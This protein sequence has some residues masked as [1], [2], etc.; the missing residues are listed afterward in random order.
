MNRTSLALLLIIISLGIIPIALSQNQSISIESDIKTGRAIVIISEDYSIDKLKSEMKKVLEKVSKEEQD[1]LVKETFNNIAKNNNLLSTI[2]KRFKNIIDK[3]F[4]GYTI[5]IMRIKSY[6]EK[7]KRIVKIVVISI[8]LISKDERK[9]EE[10]SKLKKHEEGHAKINEEIAKRLGP[11]LAKQ[12][13]RKDMNN[14]EV[15]RAGNRLRS[16]LINTQN[17]AHSKYDKLTDHGRK[18]TAS[19]QLEKADEAISEV[20][21]ESNIKLKYLSPKT[22]EVPP[23]TLNDISSILNEYWRTELRD[24]NF[25]QLIDIDKNILELSRNLMNGVDFSLEFGKNAEYAS[26][27]LTLLAIEILR[28][29]DTILNR[30]RAERAVYY[31]VNLLYYAQSRNINI[32]Q[33]RR[34]Y[35]EIQSS[36]LTDNYYNAVL[37]A[38]DISEIIL[39]KL[40]PKYQETKPYTL[41]LVGIFSEKEPIKNAE[42]LIFNKETKEL[43]KTSSDYRGVSII[44][45]SP[46][47]C[48]YLVPIKM[49]IVGIPLISITKNFLSWSSG[50]VKAPENGILIISI[51]IK[52]FI[53]FSIAMPIIENIPNIAI[54]LI[55]GVILVSIWSSRKRT[56]ISTK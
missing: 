56:R 48:E 43:Y 14:E 3:G 12:Y 10:V 34:L 50:A 37:R 33:E 40:F 32:S 11:Q 38:R 39:P 26:K 2:A 36:L 35:D 1:T 20:L 21:K 23:L 9:P 53:P 27:G 13:F 54:A 24:L 41:V 28:S 45:I 22:L 52:T 16:D 4:N 44:T 55:L 15:K 47:T 7:D 8:M 5:P 42:I 51:S 29:N 46:G 17:K 6:T 49:N 30:Y 25:T 19:D 31:I 18:G